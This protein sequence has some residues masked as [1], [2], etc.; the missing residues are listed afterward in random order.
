ML[1]NRTDLDEARFLGFLHGEQSTRLNEAAHAE[2]LRLIDGRH[3]LLATHLPI[4]L[5][6]LQW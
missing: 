1:I 5:V 2:E 6:K 3:F 4:V